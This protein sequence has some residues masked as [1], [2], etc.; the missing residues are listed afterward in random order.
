MPPLISDQRQALNF[1]Q[2]KR[3]EVKS[4]ETIENQ[5]AA[6]RHREPSPS[7]PPNLTKPHIRKQHSRKSSLLL[8]HARCISSS[9]RARKDCCSRR[10]KTAT[11]AGR[12]WPPRTSLT[13]K[14]EGRE[15]RLGLSGPQPCLSGVCK[16]RPGWKSSLGGM[17]VSEKPSK[18][19]FIEG[20]RLSCANTLGSGI[21]RGL[22]FLAMSRVQS[23]R[24]Q[25]DSRVNW[26]ANGVG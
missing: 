23:T 1:L 12:R 10:V 21:A 6:S 17:Q 24:T 25:H 3:K 9:E 11:N 4:N 14:L 20:S 22:D 26:R 13:E 5:Q 16:R 18:H 7:H 8:V 2:K 15:A 19:V